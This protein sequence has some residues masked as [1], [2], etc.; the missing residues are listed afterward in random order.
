MKAY[1]S[2]RTAHQQIV[3]VDVPTSIAETGE[4]PV[5]REPGLPPRV[6]CAVGWQYREYLREEQRSQPGSPTRQPRWGGAGMHRRPNRVPCAAAALGT[7][8]AAGLSPRAAKL[9]LW[10]GAR[11]G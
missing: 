10:A 11:A 1:R 5:I 8:N 9:Q 4:N 7:P 2:E 3:H 6:V